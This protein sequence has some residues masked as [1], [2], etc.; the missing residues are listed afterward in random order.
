MRDALL[1]RHAREYVS[2]AAIAVVHLGLGE[3]DAALDWTERAHAERRGWM[4]YLAVNPIFDP[5]R[6]MPR[7]QALL[8][9]MRLPA[10]AR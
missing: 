6:D 1:A 10:G 4:A 2:P 7:F 5:V 8:E 3:H 9:A